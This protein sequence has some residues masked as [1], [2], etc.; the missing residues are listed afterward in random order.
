MLDENQCCGASSCSAGIQFKDRLSNT[1]ESDLP[2]T[3]SHVSTKYYKSCGSPCTALHSLVHVTRT[4][5]STRCRLYAKSHGQHSGITARGRLPDA[6]SIYSTQAALPVAVHVSMLCGR[7]IRLK[8]MGL[9]ILCGLRSVRIVMLH[10]ATFTTLQHGGMLNSH[11]SGRPAAPCTLSHPSDSSVVGS[12]PTATASAYSPRAVD[13]RI[14]S[15][16]LSTHCSRRSDIHS[17]SRHC[18][19]VSGHTDRPEAVTTVSY[20]S[21]LV[22]SASSKGAPKSPKRQF[23]SDLGLE[24]QQTGYAESLQQL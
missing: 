11:I 20:S 18:L 13:L 9:A 6:T 10:L 23:A 17:T 5:I 3:T 16:R 4:S 19:A 22:A 8:L 15:Y 24:E 12:L 21:L 7:G 2:Q 1:W 14:I